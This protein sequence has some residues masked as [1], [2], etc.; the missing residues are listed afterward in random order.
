MEL[1]DFENR[2]ARQT[3]VYLPN[4]LWI[5]AKQNLI[6]LKQ[7]MIFGVKFLIAEKSGYDYPDNKLMDKIKRLSKI[8]EEQGEEIYKL[9][10]PIDPNID[11]E[12]DEILGGAI[13]GTAKE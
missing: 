11:A 3:S 2:G 5:S 12:A 10:N 13:N 7:A 8:I 4:D 6:E 9:K 1:D